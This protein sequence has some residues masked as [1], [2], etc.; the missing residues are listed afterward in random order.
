MSRRCLIK[1]HLEPWEVS[2]LEDNALTFDRRAR[3]WVPCLRDQLL[4]RL[5][6]RTGCRVS[7][8]LGLSVE[9][10]DLE[11]GI[12]KIIREKE[13]LRLFHACGRRLSRSDIFC[14][15]CGQKVTEV[16]KRLQESRRQRILPLDKGTLAM[17]R[18]FIDGG[19]PIMKDGRQLLFP[20]GRNQARHMIVLAAKRAGLGPLTNPETG[21]E[22]QV[23]PHRL[24]D[25]F[26]T[27]AM[28]MD[29]SGE[30]QRLLQEQLGHTSF[31]TTAKYRKV[32]SKEQR[33][34]YERLWKDAKP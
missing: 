29:D 18:E 34:W 27:M 14:A 21:R 9:D 15:G 23:S 17:L 7:E 20:I 28:Q 3:E 22:H 25:A 32:G 19:G 26:G 33:D 8:A 2:L 1:T 5:L 31:N 4:I 16:E 30:G 11:Q 13:R 12:I 10:L 24:R 6:F